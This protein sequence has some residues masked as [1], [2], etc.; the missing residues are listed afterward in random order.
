MADPVNPGDWDTAYDYISDEAAVLHLNLDL[1]IV[2][3]WY[4][5]QCRDDIVAIKR[6]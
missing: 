4:L 1:S 6:Q 3:D 5:S 2:S